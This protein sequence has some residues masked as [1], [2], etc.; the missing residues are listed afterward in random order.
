MH[1]IHSIHSI[2]TV[3]SVALASILLACTAVASGERSRQTD[4][5]GVKGAGEP[6]VKEGAP[7]GGIAGGGCGCLGDLDG[8]GVVDA[9]DL[10]RLL[11]QWGGNGDADFD[12]SGTVD[13][14]DLAV[15]LGAWGPCVSVPSNDDCID[16]E[17]IGV[18][19]WDFCTTDATTDGPAYPAGSP[20]ITFNYNQV[21][22]DVWYSFTA[23]GDG[24]LNVETCGTSW[25]T[26]LAI[27]GAS[28]PGLDG[29]PSEGISLIGLLAC[30]DDS[31]GFQSKVSVN[32]KAGHVYK[33]RVG[34]FNGFSGEG[35]LKVG[36][37]SAGQQCFN[38]IPVSNWQNT[39]VLGTTLDNT[40]GNDDSPCAAG[41]T[42]AEWYAFENTCGSENAKITISTCN[43][44][45]NFDTVLAVFKD[46]INGCTAVPVACNDDSTL[47]GCQIDGANRKSS[48]TFFMSPGAVY[49]VRVAGYQGATGNFGLSFLV[50]DCN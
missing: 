21:F 20:C 39:L 33:I 3:R 27:Y 25:D 50:E 44:A 11:G 23:I 7:E 49:F 34:G 9:A 32:A 48:V 43:A 2:M 28:F 6:S 4:D 31:C 12:G 8:S 40:A 26:R 15:L 41:D 47:P 35:T 18:G 5:A 13:A 37:T 17:P 19:E 22:K 45:T 14:A 46:S 10:A 29:C 16:A 1:S 30:N 36:F 38:P 24:V 42:V